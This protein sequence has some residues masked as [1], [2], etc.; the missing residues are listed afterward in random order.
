MG[1]PG[2]N[3]VKN[4]DENLVRNLGGN[5]DGLDG[6]LDTHWVAMKKSIQ[7]CHLSET[8]IF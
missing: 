5:L 6:N 3:L 1:I 2:K 4:F 8:S 7:Q